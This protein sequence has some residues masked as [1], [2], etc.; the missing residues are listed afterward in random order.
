M[1]YKNIENGYII[2]IGTGTG[3]VE[4]TEDEYNAI[5]AVIKT[6]PEDV[7]GYT[8]R[9]LEDLT[10]EQVE[11]PPVEEEELSADEALDIILGG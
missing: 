8:H 9:L 1:Y 6:R 11:A 10:W 2:C 4:I 5:M 7:D 3:D